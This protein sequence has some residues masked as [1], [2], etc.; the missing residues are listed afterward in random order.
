[1]EHLIQTTYSD[2]NVIIGISFV[3]LNQFWIML[4][5]LEQHHICRGS[6]GGVG[7]VAEHQD[8]RG[9][10]HKEI[11]GR[12]FAIIN[13][14]MARKKPFKKGPTKKLQRETTKE[15]PLFHVGVP[16]EDREVTKKKKGYG[17][18]LKRVGFD[19]SLLPN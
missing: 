15:Q 17:D 12:E 2:E 6:T 19:I 3:T 7:H 16:S 1:M 14:T 13:E 4:V 18:D 9:K 11:L 10:S 8:L 5:D